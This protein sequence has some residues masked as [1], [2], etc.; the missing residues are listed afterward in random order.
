MYAIRS[1]YDDSHVAVILGDDFHL[2]GELRVFLIGP[3][4]VLAQ[5]DAFHLDL[6]AELENVP[7]GAGGAGAADHAV[8]AVFSDVG[9]DHGLAFRAAQHRVGLGDCDG[10]GVFPVRAELVV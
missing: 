3:H 9:L 6:V 10:G 5:V 1:Y 8:Q 4:A 7:L 2:A